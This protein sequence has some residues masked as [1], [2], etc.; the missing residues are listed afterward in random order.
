MHAIDDLHR[1]RLEGKLGEGA[2]SEVFA[3]TDADTGNPVVL[4]RPHPT[5]IMR[6]QHHAVERRMSNVI[7]LRE[8]LGH[9]LPYISELI[10]YTA[11][12]EHDEYFCDSLVGEYI[13][14]VEE[15][16]QGIPLVGSAIDGIK[17]HP[18]GAPQNL[19]ALHPVI[20]HPARGRFSIVRDLF[21]VAEAFWS[22]GSL[23][24]DMRPQNIYFE[25]GTAVITVIDIGGVTEARP[26]G[27]RK[28]PLDLHDFYLEMFKWYVP[29]DDPP[30]NAAGYRQPVGMDTVPMFNH[31]L[32]TMI[33]RLSETPAAPWK[34]EAI[35]ILGKIKRRGYPSIQVFR[36]DFAKLIALLDRHY[37]DLMETG[38]KRKAWHAALSFLEDEYWRKY[39]FNPSGLKGYCRFG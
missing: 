25:P 27:G 28:P 12:T 13:V 26:A 18:V 7:A 15:R 8:K 30:L 19:F 11:P 36:N 4:K 33:R 20:P 1:F 22:A 34:S 31:N 39:R 3:A 32:D 17:G 29:V 35:D 14:A 5:L 16:A 23:L 24:L 10:A 2:D 37:D 38:H 6:A 9:A 21:E